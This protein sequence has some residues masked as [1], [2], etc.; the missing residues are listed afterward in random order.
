MTSAPKQLSN[1]LDRPLKRS[2]LALHRMNSKFGIEVTEGF[3]DVRSYVK[4]GSDFNK[5]LVNTLSERAELELNYAKGLSK[6][7]AKLFKASKEMNGTVSNAWHF[8]AEDIEATADIHKNMSSVMVEDLVK[9]LKHF[10]D[11]HHKS[12]KSIESLI[13][14]RSK[15]LQEARIMENKTKVKCYSVC[16]ENERVQDQVLDCKLGRGR[17]LTDKE[18]GKL[19]TKRRKSEESVRK[20]DL[21][22]YSAC[23]KAERARYY[24]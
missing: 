8:I 19:Q 11:I 5:E 13:D 21:E 17:V 1:M 20:T 10:V 14:K 22:Y 3:E 15:T 9:P 24:I 12:R 6:L 7:S 18:L 2:T 16:K 23:L 4:A